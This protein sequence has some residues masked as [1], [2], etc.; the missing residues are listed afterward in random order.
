MVRRAE[1]ANEMPALLATYDDACL[2][3]G[4]SSTTTTGLTGTSK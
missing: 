3:A 1:A 4:R 2:A